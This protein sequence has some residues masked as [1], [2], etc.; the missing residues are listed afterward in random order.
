MCPRQV[1]DHVIRILG[2]VLARGTLVRGF[3]ADEALLDFRSEVSDHVAADGIFGNEL[4]GA[5]RTRPRG[6]TRAGSQG[7]DLKMYPKSILRL[8]KSYF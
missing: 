5:H 8:I 2:L 7:G 4:H 3:L 1:D 6:K